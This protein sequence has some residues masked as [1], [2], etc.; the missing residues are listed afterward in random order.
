MGRV[1]RIAAVPGFRGWGEARGDRRTAQVS[2]AGAHF[3]V[4]SETAGTGS[5]IA[6][7]GGKIDPTE[8]SPPRSQGGVRD[9]VKGGVRLMFEVVQKHKRTAEEKR[10]ILL[11]LLAAIATLAIIVVLVWLIFLKG[12]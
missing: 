7:V 11:E 5:A 3:S 2:A 8:D 4:L 12:G 10:V 6:P 1:F 9:G